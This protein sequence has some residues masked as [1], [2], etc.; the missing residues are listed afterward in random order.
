MIIRQFF[1]LS[2][3]FSISVPVH[4]QSCDSPLECYERALAVIKSQEEALKAEREEIRVAL[5]SIR[6][7]LILTAGS[8]EEVGKNWQSIPNTLGKYVRI[9]PKN[10]EIGKDGGSNVLSLTKAN[11]PPHTHRYNDIYHAENPNHERMPSVRNKY[12]GDFEAGGVGSE[13]TDY[14]NNGGGAQLTRS[15]IPK[16]NAAQK[17]NIEPEYIFLN[18]CKYSQ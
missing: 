12:R 6:R 7:S 13:G 18:I 4:A 10:E 11:L 14:D 5:G 8:C 2:V 1:A 15:T 3:F 9:A 16:S 17:I